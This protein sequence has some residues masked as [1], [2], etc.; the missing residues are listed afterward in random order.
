M[1]A[2]VDPSFSEPLLSLRTSPVVSK[3]HQRT[4]RTMP[5]LSTELT[6]ATTEPGFLSCAST[7]QI[8]TLP[9]AS[10]EAN[11]AGEPGNA[12]D[13]SKPKTAPP[14]PP[15]VQTLTKRRSFLDQH[16]MLLS[17]EQVKR[18]C[19]SL[20]ET[21]FKIGLSWRDMKMG[22]SRSSRSRCSRLRRRSSSSC[23]FR[24]ASSRLLAAC[25]AELPGNSSTM[26]EFLSKTSVWAGNFAIKAAT[27]AIKAGFV[28]NFSTCLTSR[29]APPDCLSSSFKTSRNFLATFRN[30]FSSSLKAEDFL[31]VDSSRQD[32][33]DKPEDTSQQLCT[34]HLAM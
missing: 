32:I 17:L 6:G 30:S 10:P 3:G 9:S 31:K 29:A 20:E 18:N 24:S 8:S 5:P 16:M 25:F 28:L 21:T 15:S 12:T 34:C 26:S 27:S 13:M 14:C 22:L 23:L 33:A 11:L 4:T 7:G 1:V 2:G 19:P